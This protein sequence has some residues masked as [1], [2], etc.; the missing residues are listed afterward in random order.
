MNRDFQS[1]APRRFACSGKTFS[2]PRKS[3]RRRSAGSGS[4]GGT[5]GRLS[6]LYSDRI[7]PS[8]ARSEPTKEYTM[9]VDGGCHCG[10]ITLRGRD[11]PGRRRHLLLHG[12]PATLGDD[13]PGGGPAARGQVHLGLRCTP[14]V[15]QDRRERRPTRAGVLPR[16]RFADLRDVDGRRPED[17]QPAHGHLEPARPFEG[18]L[19]T[20][21]PKHRINPAVAP[22]PRR[23][24]PG[25]SATLLPE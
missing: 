10:S 3:A 4:P 5:Q 16:V 22:S 25:L 6:A 11:R 8:Q 24:A 7:A 18:G 20:V 2:I 12:L 9:K 14:D 21:V 13:V 23:Q 15:R 19:Y 1:R 17:L